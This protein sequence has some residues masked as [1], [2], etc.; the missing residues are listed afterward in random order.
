STLSDTTQQFS[1]KPV[2]QDPTSSLTSPVPIVVD[3]QTQSH[4]VND[5]TVSGIVHSGSFPWEYVGGIAGGLLLL[6]L[7][8]GAFLVGYCCLWKKRP[9]AKNE[10]PGET[11]FGI[12]EGGEKVQGRIAKAVEPKSI[13]GESV[14]G[15]TAATTTASSIAAPDVADFHL[16]P[17]LLVVLPGFGPTVL[18][19]G[20]K[21]AA[22]KI[23]HKVIGQVQFRNEV[24]QVD[25]FSGKE[26]AEVAALDAALLEECQEVFAAFVR[27]RFEYLH[28]AIT[29]QLQQPPPSTAA[30]ATATVKPQ[31]SAATKPVTTAGTTK[32]TIQKTMAPSKSKMKNDEEE[33][34]RYFKSRETQTITTTRPTAPL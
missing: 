5:T 31:K 32:T 17:T 9:G 21:E 7:I 10:I 29:K 26:F 18:P 33:K 16:P 3:K 24:R 6:A 11:T 27:A 1:H 13:V 23:M 30:P 25:V 14:A 12:N 22:E 34:R 2:S 8:I 28:K 4:P 15:T 19:S 20:Y